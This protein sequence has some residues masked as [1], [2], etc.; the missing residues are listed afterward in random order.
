MKFYKIIIAMIIVNININCH[1]RL[2]VEDT[3]G[4]SSTD[5]QKV[6]NVLNTI[7]SSVTYDGPN[8]ENK[9]VIKNFDITLISCKGELDKFILNNCKTS[10]QGGCINNVN[11]VSTSNE[12]NS[13]NQTSLT[14]NEQISIGGCKRYFCCEKLTIN[15]QTTVGKRRR[16]LV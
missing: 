2:I 7:F 10:K 4:I 12:C 6:K 14:G 5:Y 15:S 13:V 3:D 16:R 9:K 8:T 11:I 1:S